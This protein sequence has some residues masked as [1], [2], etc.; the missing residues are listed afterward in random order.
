MSATGNDAKLPRRSMLKGLG[1]IPIA[2]FA[3]ILTRRGTDQPFISLAV[4]ITIYTVWQKL[5][6]FDVHITTTRKKWW[7][8]HP[9]VRASR[10]LP[11]GIQS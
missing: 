5:R 11:K 3:P 2:A 9:G 7:P 8:G 10:S 6:G 1:A 4:V